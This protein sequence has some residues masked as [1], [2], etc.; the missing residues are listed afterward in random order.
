MHARLNWK[1]SLFSSKIVLLYSFRFEHQNG[2]DS[3]LLIDILQSP[4]RA[5]EKTRVE[6][7]IHDQDENVDDDDE[8]DDDDD[9]DD[10]DEDEDSNG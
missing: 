7:G 2:V 6:D 10:K 5:C 3:I 4:L 8:D 9:D 1:F